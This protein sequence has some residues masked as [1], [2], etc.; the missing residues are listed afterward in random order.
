M[1]PG[2]CRKESYTVMNFGVSNG[3]G[4]GTYC[5]EIKVMVDTAK[6]TNMI[7][8]GFRERCNLARKDSM[9]IKDEAKVASRLGGID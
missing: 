7:I 9:F 6:L 1:G 3:D 5:C 8:A 4:S 2:G